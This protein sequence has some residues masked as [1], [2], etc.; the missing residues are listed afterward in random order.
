MKTILLTSSGKFVTDGDMLFLAKPISQMKLAYITTAA[1]GVQ[2]ASYVN[3]RKQ[4]M[5]E[6]NFNFEEV[7]LD[8]KNENELMKILADKEII[9]VE[10]GNTFYL[11]KTVRESGFDNVIKNLIDKGVIYIGS[12]AGSYIACPTIEMNLWK[13]PDINRYN[14]TDLTGLNLVS[15]L[16]TVHYAPEFKELLK[17]KIKNSKY[18]VKILTDEQALLVRDGEVKLLGKGDE[19]NI[20]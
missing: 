6:L 4:R 20:L 19:I 12:S 18:P 8:G 2:D 1:K 14:L 5:A 15:F 9:Y 16:V 13:H 3:A 11:L 7:D 10:G 17:E